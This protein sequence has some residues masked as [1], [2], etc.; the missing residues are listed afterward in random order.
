M[1]IDY[2]LHT[3]KHFDDQLVPDIRTAQQ[4]QVPYRLSECNSCSVGGKAGVSNTFASALWAVDFM[5]SV[6]VAGGSGVNLHG[7]GDSMYTPI[8]GSPQRGF[9]ARPV[10]Y[11]MLVAREFLGGKLL[12]TDLDAGGSDVKAYAS[13]T[14]SGLRV[15]VINREAM[16]VSVRLKVQHPSGR[17]VGNVWRL[18]AP[19]LSSETGV[20]VADASVTGDGLFT[21]SRREALAFHDGE[22]ALHLDPHSA[23]LVTVNEVG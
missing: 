8:A 12:E 3:S 23:A 20:T 4:S 11:G 13:S 5:V 9:S 16:P 15:L 19:S 17:G 22:S 18:Q 6:A 21:P 14:A 1:T 7:G 2:L 10:Y